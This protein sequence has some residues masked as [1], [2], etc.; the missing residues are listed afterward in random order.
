MWPSPI[1]V[2]R[3]LAGTHGRDDPETQ[4]GWR[5][6]ASVV[7]EI[8][9]FGRRALAL[10]GDVGDAEDV[11]RI[12]ADTIAHFGKVDILVNNT[13]ERPTVPTETGRGSFPKRPS[14]PSC[15]SI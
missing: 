7:K 3:E 13:P 4:A 14:T 2:L 11:E 5:G 15:A 10:T 1:S 9:G 6:L 12:V 8:E